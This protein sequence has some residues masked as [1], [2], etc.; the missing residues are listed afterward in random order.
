MKMRKLKKAQRAALRK[1]K[2][3]AEITLS[4]QE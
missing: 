1:Q 3:Y 4:K 2:Q